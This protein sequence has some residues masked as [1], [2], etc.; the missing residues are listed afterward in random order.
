[1]LE[2]LWKPVRPSFKTKLLLSYMLLIAIPL[3][4]GS[5]LMY[6]QFMVSY[7]ENTSEMVVQRINQEVNNINETLSTIERDAFILSSNVTFS[8]FLNE[9]YNP[10]ST[11]SHSYLSYRILPM[12]A[13]FRDTN[14]NISKIN[15]LTFNTSIPEIDVFT[16]AP[17]YEHKEWFTSMRDKTLL[18]L[19]YWENYHMQRSYRLSDKI[20]PVTAP[21]Y[22]LFCTVNSV[23]NTKATYL[24]LQIK[25]GPLYGSLDLS[26]VGKSGFLA[27]LDVKN[28][29]ISNKRYPIL[30]ALIKDG[31]FLSELEKPDGEYRYAFNNVDYNINFKRIERLNA[32]VVS[33]VPTTEI[34][35]LFNESRQNYIYSI[36][37]TFLFLVI[38]AYYLGNLFTKKIKK[39]ASAF[40]RFQKGDFDTRIAVKGSDELD[41]LSMDF[42]IMASRI[43][44]LINK[45]YKSEIAQKQAELASLQA[46][47]KPHF[48]YNTLESLKMKAELHDDEEISDGLTALGNLM[49]Q[50]T[51]TD[52]HLISLD[53]E[54]ENLSDYIKIQNLLRN[55]G[56]KASFEIPEEIRR[57]D[58]LNLVLQPIIENCIVHGHDESRGSLAIT[59]KGE[60]ID[61][62][63]LI[64]ISD[65]GRGIPEGKLTGLSELLRSGRDEEMPKNSAAGI[66]IANVHRRIK[67]YFGNDYGLS[68]ESTLGMGT[69][70][71]VKIPAATGSQWTGNRNAHAQMYSKG[72]SLHVPFADS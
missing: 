33:V 54:L 15:A 45:V 11:E 43:Q 23:Y 18:G 3:T 63:I 5:I 26:P 12:F 67:L 44:E 42:N 31:G 20:N 30:T 24:E 17:R 14:P 61:D 66:G 51:R 40:H 50:N 34:T 7:K 21:V 47:I 16:H 6:R 52:N 2:V 38:L 8:A 60:K 62:S 39:I 22:S 1:M 59:V 36:G 13:W 70:V 27:V 55:N 28:G 46:Q 29:I 35:E 58:I 32:C 19:P 37:I 9:D 69:A 4:I 64:T 25:P 10:L 41:L 65:N 68:I 57:Y 48:I 72:G 56:I 71:R 53:S 49:R